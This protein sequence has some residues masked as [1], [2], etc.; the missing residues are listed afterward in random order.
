MFV[1]TQNMVWAQS[2]CDA[3]LNALTAAPLGAFL[4]T[5]TIRLFVNNIVVGPQTPLTA[6]T[7]ATFT[8]YAAVTMGTLFGPVTL[9]DGNEAKY[10]DADYLCS[11]APSPSVLVYGYYVTNAGSTV[12]YGGET[13]PTPVPIAAPGDF[14]SLE[15]IWAEPRIHTAV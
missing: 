13:F 1:A 14:V 7:E 6:F 2:L 9:P 8:G 15:L 11:A 4:T 12:Y 3:I 10:A 5:P